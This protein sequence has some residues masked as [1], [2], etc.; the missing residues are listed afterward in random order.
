MRLTLLILVRLIALLGL[1]LCL[2]AVTVSKMVPAEADATSRSRTPQAGCVGVN[3][4]A[5]GTQD[6]RTRLVHPDDG[7]L[8]TL[9]LP[10][11]EILEEASGAPWSENG[12]GSQVVGRWIKLH[13]A[14]SVGSLLEGV[15]LGRFSLPDGRPLNRV[16]TN[17]VPAS[18][19]CWGPSRASLI[20]YASTSGNLHRVEFEDRPAYEGST[21]V[22]PEVI[23]WQCPRPG[24]GRVDVLDICWPAHDGLGGRLVASIRTQSRDEAGMFQN[25][26]PQLWWVELDADAR[27]IVAVGRL[28]R[29]PG[30]GSDRHPSVARREDGTM[31]LTYLHYEPRS[32]LAQLVAVPLRHD[33]ALGM[34]VVDEGQARVL[35]DHCL[36]SRP[37]PSS[38]GLSIAVVQSVVATGRPAVRRVSLVPGAVAACEVPAAAAAPAPA[39][40]HGS[41]G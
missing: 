10:V 13:G 25:E 5:I 37:A 6:H 27:S 8:I 14:G 30:L 39:P 15:G 23:R 19:P 28:T 20:V 29:R 38:D 33:D 31:A 22:T 35:A 18:P 26:D 12:G 41:G 3:A 7:R 17:D 21:D 2:L 36:A 34:T 24:A 16:L 11:D 1:S 40:D 32:A 4:A 9:D